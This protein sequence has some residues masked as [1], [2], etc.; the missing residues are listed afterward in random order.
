[1]YESPVQV[2]IALRV[3]AG[4][5]SSMTCFMSSIEVMPV[6][7]ASEGE[8]SLAFLDLPHKE[9]VTIGRSVGDKNLLFIA[10]AVKIPAVGHA[11]DSNKAWLIAILDGPVELLIGARMLSVSQGSLGIMVSSI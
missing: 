8:E 1:M 4:G 7:L 2:G 10:S 3:S 9:F 6:G 5:I 11:L